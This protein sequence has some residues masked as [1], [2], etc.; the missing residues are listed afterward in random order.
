MIIS[1]RNLFNSLVIFVFFF[2]F[3]T[4]APKAEATT[5]TS[6]S[7]CTGGSG[8]WVAPAG[9][10]SVTAEVWGAGGAGAGETANND[11]GE[12]GG[13]GGAYS[14]KLN[15][16]VVPGN[17]YAVTIGAAGVGSTGAGTAGGDSWFCNAT[18][19]CA[20]IAGTSVQ[21]GAKGGGGGS[22]NTSHGVGG[23]SASGFGDTK[24]SGGN[25]GDGV[26][27][28]E[29]IGSGGGG[30]A[31]GS[32]ANGGVGGNGSAGPTAGAAGVGNDG[33]GNGGAGRSTGGT[34]NN[35]STPGGGGG[36]TFIN[37]NTNRSGGAG[38]SGQVTLTYTTV[39]GVSSS[40][41]NGSY[42]AAQVVPI[43]VTFSG[44]VT[45]TGT[46]QITL[47]TGTPATTAINYSSGSGS[48]VLI[49]NYTVAAG[50]TSADLDYAS[51]TALALNGGTIVNAAGGSA[52]LTLVSPGAAG[53][54]GANKAIVIDTTSP[55]ISTIAPATDSFINSITT[56]SDVSYTLSENITSGSITM[57]RTSGTADGSSP[58]ICTLKGTALNTGTHTAFNMSNITNSCTISQS[59]VSGAVYTFAFN[60]TD[61]A[62]NTATA[63]SNT[64]VIFDTT[65]PT[66]V[67]T[68]SDADSIVKAGDSL[69]ITATFSEPINDS[70]I[71]KIAISGANTLSAINMTKIDTTH[72]TYIH[73]VGAGNGLATIALS[74]GT[75]LAGNVITSA[76]TFGMTFTVDNI[77]PILTE[78]TP[79]ITLTNDNT[80]NYT[81]SSTEAGTITYGGDCSSATT[82]AVSGNNTITFNIL[83]DGAHTNCT[84][85][86][87]DAAGNISSLLNVT[88]F[89]VN[90]AG[91]VLTPVS[92]ASNNTNT[93]FAKDGN[94]VTLSFTANE[95]INIPTVTFNSGGAPIHGSITKV[96]TNGNNWTASYTVVP[97]DTDGVITFTIDSTN[98]LGTPGL[99]ITTTTDSSSVTVDK[100]I[101]TITE[102][103]PVPIQ[104][105]DN[106]PNYTFSST[107]AGTITY[108]G[109]CSSATTSAVSGNNTITFN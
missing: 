95:T 60:A 11:G 25:G 99:Q 96:N 1:K 35:G 15:I 38:A 4:L 36:G 100:V 22:A 10:T 93:S 37:N 71:V 78:V 19:N 63:V 31:G 5:C 62:G 26:S 13:G 81:F 55:V 68:Y 102:I 43:T 16:T 42:K 101:P 20:T 106:T 50:N 33:G 24:F 65:A 77:V 76:P 58:H 84:I 21:S 61:L 30:G 64:G 82:S 94:V 57:T 83:A 47:S 92:I 23:A 45:V 12:S 52:I 79:V 9:V 28:N 69:I 34:G 104:T 107:E 72:Y 109:D 97:A 91:P 53:S 56:S 66:A 90:T 8:S 75:D 73:T 86:V 32:T 87:T 85:T 88:A 18:T 29:N 89:T 108:G 51:T 2:S 39:T 54:L 98:T 44:A 27:G 105:S 49:F 80:P 40:L 70:P 59:L 17:S 67:I 46:P 74:I 6:G 103:T 41:A 3:F 48:S 7:A 14:K